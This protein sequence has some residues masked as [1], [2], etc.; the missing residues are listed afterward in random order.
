M[1]TRI[2]LIKRAALLVLFATLNSQP[3]TQAEDT[4]ITYQGRFNTNNAPYTGAAEFQFTLWDAAGGGSS[5]ATNNPTSVIATVTAGLFTAML[6][7]GSNPFN[8]QPRFLQVEARTAIGAFAPL[9]P[10][11]PLTP[12]PYALRAL[13]LTTNGLAAG[14]YANAVTFNNPGNSFFGAFNGNGSGLNNVNATT[15]GGM[16]A[17]SFWQLGGNAGSNPASDFIGTRD[18]QPLEFRVNGQIALR[19][20][21]STSGA[22]NLVGGSSNNMID[23]GVRGSTISGGG[24]SYIGAN[25][26]NRVS[27]DFGTVAGGAANQISPNAFFATISGGLGNLIHTNASRAT[28]SGGDGNV[29]EGNDQVFFANYSVIAGGFGNLIG[30]QNGGATISGGLANTIHT[31]AIYASIS[32]GRDNVI[33]TT[34][35]ASSIGGGQRN[36]IE[37]DAAYALIGGGRDNLIRS[38]AFSSAIGGGE[39]NVIE[40]LA[41]WSLIG[42]GLNNRISTSYGT[43]GGGFGNRIEQFSLGGT[44]G[45]GQANLIQT[46]VS[47]GTIPGGLL[48]TVE[49]NYALAA[50]YR[51][52]A[53]HAGSFVWADTIDGDFPSTST[54]QFSVRATGGVRFVSAVDASTSMPASGV[55]LAV[56]SGSWSSLSDRNAKE[57]FTPV[58]AQAILEKVAALPLASWRYKAEA[59]EIKHI[60]P[61]E[62]DFHAAFGVGPDDK[63][64]ATV[65]ADGVALAAIQGLNQK[66]SEQEARLK[67][68]DSEIQEL[69]QAVAALQKIVNQITHKTQE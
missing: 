6:D 68:K 18:S 46:N 60:G 21:P 2:A 47:Y 25:Y 63:H 28:I 45:G 37:R 12:T 58:D 65:D 56:G 3:S 39:G 32:G 34:A 5:V 42:G 67:K 4:A 41:T 20:E 29:I 64:I 10:R 23:T 44:I 53:K 52:K 15:V 7:F 22:P 54:N 14:T 66:L 17:A 11:Q 38:A 1:K 26:T 61:M 30:R 9:T 69:R 49:G 50:G 59:H 35:S 24:G 27:A 13:N 8:G 16:S 55:E 36:S 62:Q 33:G 19:L 51:G 57:N 40:T 31:N 43:V 48:N